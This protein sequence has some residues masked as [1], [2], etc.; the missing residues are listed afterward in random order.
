MMDKL[1]ECEYAALALGITI[2]Q[3]LDRRVFE[4][5]GA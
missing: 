3:L 4:K 5:A 2:G 1:E